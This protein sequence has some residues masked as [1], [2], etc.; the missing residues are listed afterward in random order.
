VRLELPVLLAARLGQVVRIVLGAHR[1][2]LLARRLEHVGD[3][4]RE[5]RVAAL[6]GRRTSWPLTQTRAE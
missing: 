6:V 4:G 5:R 3:V 1:H 2:D